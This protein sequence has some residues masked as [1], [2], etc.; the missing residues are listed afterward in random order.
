MTGH[1]ADP[2]S[3][4]LEDLMDQPMWV[5]WQ[6]EIRLE[7]KRPTKV[8]YAPSGRKAASDDPTTWGT[9]DQ[10]ADRADR[11]PLPCGDGGVGIMF[12]E[13][14]N[15][16]SLAGVD[17]DTCFVTDGPDEIAPWGEEVI[18]R[19]S[20]Y[21]EFSPSGT[22]VKIFFLVKTA[23]LP[24]ARKAID[25]N[26]GRAWK[27]PGEEHP[28][29]IEL[30]LGR[31][32]FTVT[33]Q[34]VSDTPTE[35]HLVDLETVLW[36]VHEHGPKFLANSRDNRV[37]NS[38]EYSCTANA[39]SSTHA[40]TLAAALNGKRQGGGWIAHCPAHD[41]QKPSLSVSEGDGGARKM[42]TT[43]SSSG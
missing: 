2:G 26:Y 39:T 10:A 37:G 35:L 25:D 19:F 17:L 20:S 43:L 8:P 40:G 31:R 5:A 41:D 12:S 18:D 33:A 28:P 7:G 34:H 21:T 15:G 1:T 3:I 36:L 23:D 42:P 9:W 32:F 38:R 27:L 14:S 22:G 24:A 30:R 16:L 13:V 29:G 11:L 4:T 6:N